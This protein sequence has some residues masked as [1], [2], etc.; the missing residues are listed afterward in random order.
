MNVN[1]SKPFLFFCFCFFFLS[2]RKRNRPP[3]NPLRRRRKKRKNSNRATYATSQFNMTASCQPDLD[4]NSYPRATLTS[5]LSLTSVFSHS[6]TPMGGSHRTH[7]FDF[8]PL[9]HH[10]KT[11]LG[12]VYPYIY[13]GFHVYM[14]MGVLFTLGYQLISNVIVCVP[15]DGSVPLSLLGLN[16]YC[17][18]IFCIW[19]F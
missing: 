2:R 10:W 14:Y 17:Y 8:F 5:L 16:D 1:D 12:Y 7:A 3:R 6:R 18:R 4:W 13:H 19:Q 11:Q 9:R 15:G